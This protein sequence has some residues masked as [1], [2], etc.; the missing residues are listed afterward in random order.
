MDYMQELTQKIKAFEEGIKIFFKAENPYEKEL[1]E[2]MLYSLNAG[3][4]R[5]RPLLLLEVAKAYGIEEKKV[6]SHALALEMIHT[7]SL[8]HDDLPCMDDD[9]MRRGKPT[10]H[11]VFGEAM[12]V[13]TGDALLNK[14][15][16]IMVEATVVYPDLIYA[17]QTIASAAGAKGMILGQVADMKNT[18]QDTLSVET[19]DFINA[20]KTGKLIT[21]ALVAGTQA[22]GQFEDVQKMRA[23]GYH[24]GLMFQMKDDVL[25]MIGD[26]KALGKS[27]HNDDKNQKCTYP[28]LIGIENTEKGILAL[29]ERVDKQL[30]SLT[31]PQPFLK[32]TV[33]F[34]VNR[35]Y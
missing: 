32:E 29:K 1:E 16:E 20:N 31:V 25:D 9:D 3:G 15:F 22:C 21:A 8:I 30:D 2:A 19:L 11:K 27:V 7:Y 23:I 14:A 6:F 12:A 24:M 4:K 18:H 28:K 34:F 17:T 26:S 13:L 10:S 33:A 5:I 35:T